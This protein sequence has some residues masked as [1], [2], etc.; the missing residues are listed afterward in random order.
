MIS[1]QDKFL[2]KENCDGNKHHAHNNAAREIYCCGCGKILEAG[3]YAEGGPHDD[4]ADV[5]PEGED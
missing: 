4:A 1:A 5:E 2:R 3:A